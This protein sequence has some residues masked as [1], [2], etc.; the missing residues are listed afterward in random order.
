MKVTIDKWTSVASWKWDIGDHQCTI[1]MN[2]FEM[3]CDN[4][5]YAGD[6]CTLLQGECGHYFHMHCIYKWLEQ[7][8]CCPYDRKPWKEKSFDAPPLVAAAPP[9]PA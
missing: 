1:C 5:K 9:Q 2:A 6:D 4:C 8:N 3:P 7:N